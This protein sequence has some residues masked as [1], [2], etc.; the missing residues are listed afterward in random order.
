MPGFRTDPTHLP[1]EGLTL[2][3]VWNDDLI[4][5]GRIPQTLMKVALSDG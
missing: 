1:E 3:A 4:S 2:F 5:Q